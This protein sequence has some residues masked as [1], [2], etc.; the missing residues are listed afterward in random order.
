LLLTETIRIFQ[1]LELT[2][3]VLVVA[4]QHDLPQH[5]INLLNK[6]GLAVLMR[7]CNVE[8][9][10]EGDQV[11]ASGLNIYG[12]SW[13]VKLPKENPCKDHDDDGFNIGVFHFPT[14]QGEDPYGPASHV[15]DAVRRLKSMPWF[16]L[17]VVGDNHQSFV[18]ESQMDTLLSPGSLCRMSA[19]QQYHR[20]CAYLLYPGKNLLRNKPIP[21][22]KDAVSREHLDKKQDMEQGLSAFVEKVGNVKGKKLSFMARLELEMEKKEHDEDLKKVMYEAMEQE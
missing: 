8:V 1:K 17:M 21:I 13:G 14:W 4:G 12:W 19:D 15:P 11:I 16:D 9:L 3:R 18:E 22:E 6:T 20:P 2:H 7:A 5:N 10:L